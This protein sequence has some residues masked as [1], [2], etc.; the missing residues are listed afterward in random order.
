MRRRVRA[1]GLQMEVQAAGP[2][3]AYGDIIEGWSR[4]E[5]WVIPPHDT[6]PQQGER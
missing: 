4:A 5:P 3:A 2:H 6:S 1:P